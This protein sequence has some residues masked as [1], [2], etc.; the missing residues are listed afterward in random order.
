VYKRQGEEVELISLRE[1]MAIQAV[2]AREPRM[3]FHVST[4]VNEI[5]P[6]FVVMNTIEDQRAQLE[7][8]LLLEACGGDVGQVELIQK[9]VGAYSTQETKLRK[10]GLEEEFNFL[11]DMYLKSIKAEESAA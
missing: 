3:P 6:K 10:R 8:E 9:L 5:E 1:L 4:L 11:I 2:W 7:G